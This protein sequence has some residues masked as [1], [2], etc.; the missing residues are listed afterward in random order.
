V[1]RHISLQTL[2]TDLAKKEALLKTLY[3]LYPELTGYSETELL[4][5]LELRTPEEL[6]QYIQNVE[7]PDTPHAGT[8]P[9]QEYTVCRCTDGKGY[10]KELYQSEAAA[11][12]EIHAQLVHI[13][14]KLSVYPCPSGFGWH[15]TK[16]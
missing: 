5:Y 13:K 11:H 4:L 9:M 2:K 8:T 7:K 6:Y 12:K 3:G 1:K 14:T 16:R 15:L 10:P